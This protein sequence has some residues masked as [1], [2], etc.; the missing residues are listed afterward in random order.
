LAN[1]PPIIGICKYQIELQ[2]TCMLCYQSLL[3]YVVLYV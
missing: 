2:L 3:I 1:L